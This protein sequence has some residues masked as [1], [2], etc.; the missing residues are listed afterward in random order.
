MYI[1]YSKIDVRTLINKCN[2]KKNYS[3]KR[4]YYKLL[5]VLFVLY[6]DVCEYQK[7]NIFYFF[8]G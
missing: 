5:T 1:E 7:Y 3:F 6:V 8:L 2:K 4:L